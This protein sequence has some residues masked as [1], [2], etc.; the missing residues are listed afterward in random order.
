MNKVHRLIKE[1]LESLRGSISEL[2]PLKFFTTCFAN[3]LI[4][5]GFIS[6]CSVL[7]FWK[8]HQKKGD[9]DGIL[10]A[11]GYTNQLLSLFEGSRFFAPSIAS[12]FLQL[13]SIL[14]KGFFLPLQLIFAQFPVWT[15]PGIPNQVH[16]HFLYYFLCTSHPTRHRVKQNEYS[17]MRST[18]KSFVTDTSPLSM[19]PLNNWWTR[20]L[21]SLC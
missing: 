14:S 8:H 18:C 10:S 12:L 13:A 9:P 6:H 15:T 5:E 7:V 2:V 11:A 17:H 4:R 21:V 19:H 16:L 20:L 1:K 3:H